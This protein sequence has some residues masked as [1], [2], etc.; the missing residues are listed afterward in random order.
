MKTKQLLCYLAI[1]FSILL[2]NG[3][4]RNTTDANLKLDSNESF[5]IY[6]LHFTP[7]NPIAIDRKEYS[8]N[9]I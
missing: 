9:T 1:L 3:G 6:S 4:D 7:P 5:Q 8:R 2:A